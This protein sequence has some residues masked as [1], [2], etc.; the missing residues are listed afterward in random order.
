MLSPQNLI[1]KNIMTLNKYIKS[2]GTVANSSNWC[3]S[4]YIPVTPGQVYNAVG[5]SVGGNNVPCIVTYSS[6]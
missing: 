1:S 6:S 4:D 2:D 3:I 5:F